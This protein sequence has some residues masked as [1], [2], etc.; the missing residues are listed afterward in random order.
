[1]ILPTRGSDTTESE[2][3]VDWSDLTTTTE[4]GGSAILTYHLQWDA[5]VGGTSSWVDLIG[6]P[7]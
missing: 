3:Q 2:L 6:Y 4:T 5:G 1:M 7:T